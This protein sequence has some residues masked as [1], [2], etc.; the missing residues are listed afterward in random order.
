MAIPNDSSIWDLHRPFGSQLSAEISVYDWVS[1]FPS[2]GLAFYNFLNSRIDL[3]MI[4]KYTN[5]SLVSY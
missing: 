2:Q 1:A 5:K 3:N 4:I